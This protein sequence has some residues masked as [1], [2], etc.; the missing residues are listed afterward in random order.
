MFVFKVHQSNEATIEMFS[1]AVDC[2]RTSIESVLFD[3]D[4]TVVVEGDK[5][6]ITASGITEAECEDKIKGCFRQSNGAYYPEFLFIEL[7]PRKA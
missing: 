5:I 2:A 3:L 7:L 4:A 6:S 1:M